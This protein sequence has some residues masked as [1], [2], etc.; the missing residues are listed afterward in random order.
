MKYHDYENIAPYKKGDKTIKRHSHNAIYERVIEVKGEKVIITQ[1]TPHGKWGL[2]EVP[3]YAN[4]ILFGEM[5]KCVEGNGE[6]E[7]DV[8]IKGDY[9]EYQYGLSKNRRTA[10][11]QA[12]KSIADTAKKPD[13]NEV[14]EWLSK[15]MRNI[16]KYGKIAA[17]SATKSA[18]PSATKSAKRDYHKENG[19]I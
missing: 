12:C 2:P 18:T 13:E 16:A 4:G 1:G 9:C 10:F 8:L 6:W 5:S 17:S 7:F 14:D 19:I 3:I 11:L 15:V